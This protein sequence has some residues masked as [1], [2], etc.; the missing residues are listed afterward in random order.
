M[1][2]TFFRCTVTCNFLNRNSLSIAAKNETCSGN[3]PGLCNEGNH[4]LHGPWLVCCRSWNVNSEWGKNPHH[5]TKPSDLSQ[6]ALLTQIRLHTS[7]QELRHGFFFHLD[8][9]LA[10]RIQAEVVQMPEVLPY[11]FPQFLHHLPRRTDNLSQN[12]VGEKLILEIYLNAAQRT[13]GATWEDVEAI[14]Q[15]EPNSMGVVLWTYTGT[16][17]LK[18]VTSSMYLI[19][20]N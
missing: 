8:T 14:F 5:P 12:S 3:E 7:K 6:A 20:F 9:H 11:T 15:L 4:C 2:N 19:L 17:P 1:P 13:Q 16:S 10:V 18:W